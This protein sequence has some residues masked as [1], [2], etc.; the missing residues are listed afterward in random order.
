MPLKWRAIVAVDKKNGIGAN[1]ELGRTVPYDLE[2]FKSTTIGNIIVY[3]RK[4]LETFPHK[5]PLPG[6]INIVLTRNQDFKVEGALVAHS[7]DELDEILA[8]IDAEQPSKTHQVF[9][10]GGASIYE[11]L[12][13]R[14]ELA[15]L[16]HLHT[17][18]KDADAFFPRLGKMRNWHMDKTYEPIIVKT[19]DRDGKKIS[20]HFATWINDKPDKPS[21]D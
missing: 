2:H 16:T 7:V 20:L 15:F 12:L 14:C 9:V 17:I 13:S 4:T 18:V 8:K 1:G 6:R 10:C 3:G 19:K 11:L 5:K 21:V